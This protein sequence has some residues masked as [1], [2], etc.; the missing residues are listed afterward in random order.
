MKKQLPIVIV[1]I[2]FVASLIGNI[3]LYTLNCQL[4]ESVRAGLSDIESVQ[5][6]LTAKTSELAEA[7]AKIS[8][9][10]TSMSDLTTELDNLKSEYDSLIKVEA[11][12]FEKMDATMYVVEEDGA[13]A[14]RGTS[15]DYISDV[16]LSFA[17]EVKVTGQSLETKWFQI[18]MS[19][20]S[21]AYVSNNYLSLTKPT[22]QTKVVEQQPAAPT[23][24]STPSTPATPAFPDMSGLGGSI[25]SNPF[26]QGGECGTVTGSGDFAGVEIY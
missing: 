3:Y 8:E 26:I 9:F 4:N 2:L 1:S 21:I 18:K 24:P 7:N 16:L 25:G 12:A 13:P 14:R 17:Q 15:D 19:D 20:G 23:T 11:E 22:R 5:N 10:E 6:D